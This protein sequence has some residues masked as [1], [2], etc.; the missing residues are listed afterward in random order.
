MTLQH[1]LVAALRRLRS[2]LLRYI[3]LFDIM[4]LCYVA[5]LLK[6][7]QVVLLWRDI[8]NGLVLSVSVKFTL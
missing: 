6:C 7:L 4:L 8:V 3:A 5:L 2:I 1:L